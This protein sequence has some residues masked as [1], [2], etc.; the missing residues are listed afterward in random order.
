MRSRAVA[1]GTVAAVIAAAVIC[2]GRARGDWPMGRQNA[3]RT[4]EALGVSDIREPEEIWR[5][6]LGGS[7]GATG[8]AILDVDRNGVDDYVMV[9]GGALV[10]KT[11]D[12]TVLWQV[13]ARSLTGIAGLSDLDGDGALEVIVSAS[14]SVMVVE[15]RT[16]AIEWELP[17]GLMKQF[18]GIRVG[19]LDRDGLDDLVVVE[20]GPCAAAP[21]NWPGAVYS[22]AGGTVREVW[23]LPTVVCGKGVAMS[24]FDGDGDGALELLEPTFYTVQMLDGPTGSVLSATS[25]LGASMPHLQCTPVDVDGT[26]GD[27]LACIHSNPYF[28]AERSVLLLDYGANGLRQVWRNYLSNN[29]TGDMRTIELAVDLGDGLL[30]AVSARDAPDQPWTTFLYDAA[31]G[32]QRAVLPGELVAGSAPRPAGGRYLLTQ[33][34]NALRGWRAGNGGA[35]VLAWTRPGDE[36]PVLVVSRDTGQRVA[37]STRAATLPGAGR[38]VVVP[39]STQNT[40]RAIDVFD[41]GTSVAAEVQLPS[42]VKADSAF[43]TGGDDVAFAM[44]RSDGYLAP[45]DELLVLQVGVDLMRLPRTGGHVATGSFRALGGP[46]RTADVDGDDRDEVIVVDSRGALIRLDPQ[47]AATHAP[48][49]ATW[50]ANNTLFPAV[51]RGDDGEPAIACIQRDVSMPAS[52]TYALSVLGA[53]GSRRWSVALGGAPLADVIPGDLDGDTVP[54]LAVQWGLPTDQI[55][56]TAVHA[57]NDGTQLWEQVFDPGSGRSPAGAAIGRWPGQLNDVVIHIG[58]RLVWVLAGATGT[59]VTPSPDVGLSYSLPTLVEIDGDPGS[60]M[61]LTGGGY[62]VIVLDDDLTAD[63]VSSD[64]MRVFP[65]GSIAHCPDGAIVLASEAL[66]APP[67]LLLTTL[68]SG[69]AGLPVGTER[70]LWL[71][72]GAAHA[73]QAEAAAAGFLGQ[74]TSSTVHDDLTGQGR[75]STLV[76]SSDGWLYAIDPCSGTLDFAFYVSSAVGEA[77]YGDGDG[78]GKDE[79]LITAGDGYLRALQHHSIDAPAWVADLDPLTDSP[80]D[81]DELPWRETLGASWAEVSGAVSYQV[82]VVDRDGDHLLTPPWRNVP[83]TETSFPELS[84]AAERTLYVLVRAVGPA[85]TSIDRSSDGVTVVAV[86]DPPDPPLPGGCCETGSASPLAHISL[87]VIVLAVVGRRR[88]QVARRVCGHQ[89][90]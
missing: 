50:T 56:H 17:S 6:Y 81:V 13:G 82:A 57:G 37:L 36:D 40:I 41:G 16:G 9:A 86:V 67:R 21:G 70:A 89:P 60:E 33:S 34:P 85:G 87:V 47:D 90:H 51:T 74:L 64:T 22:F 77:V 30:L 39:R 58:A 71:S 26:A 49:R 28:Y 80:D 1:V 11:V 76:G 45:Y 88:R 61:V 2:T 78:D 27:E 32:T 3:Q 29:T 55:L 42:G 10:A 8:L 7:L 24:L 75:P 25:D 48:P 19:D 53:D 63:F 20:S 83:G 46:P 52:P 31:T 84:T 65:Y 44:S 59:V 66:L 4:A 12:D 54:D 5:Y 18:G 23:Q 73:T 35:P 79:I 38:V 15:A 68:S 43:V 14:A 69:A 72:A 62:G